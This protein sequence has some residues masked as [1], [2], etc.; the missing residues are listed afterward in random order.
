MDVRNSEIAIVISS[1]KREIYPLDISGLNLLTVSLKAWKKENLGC[2]LLL[3]DGKILDIISAEVIGGSW[4]NSIATAISLSTAKLKVELEPST[5][6]LE[7]LKAVICDGVKDYVTYFEGDQDIN[8][9]L[10]NKPVDDV[11]LKIKD[12]K[13]TSEIVKLLDFATVNEPMP[14]L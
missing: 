14:H 5:L 4:L 8:W 6:S 2:H 9:S 12:S 1:V 3:E 10:L 7:E 11:I 13:T